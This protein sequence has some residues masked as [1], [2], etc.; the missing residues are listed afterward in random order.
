MGRKTDGRVD[1]GGPPVMVVS[2]R[3]RTVE[4]IYADFANRHSA[5]VRALT[6]DIDEVYSLCD[7]EKDSLCLH[8]QPNGLWEVVL[9]EE[10][11]PPEI[12]EP[13]QGINFYRDAMLQKEWISLLAMHSDS[14]LLAV[15]F[16]FGAELNAIERER[17]FNLINEL[18]TLF[19]SVNEEKSN[20][21]NGHSQ[22]KSRNRRKRPSERQ[23]RILP[24]PYNNS[25]REEQEEEED[26]TLCGRCG[27][28][29]GE[30]EFWIG[31]DVCERWFH[32]K[33]V[34]VTPAKAETIEKYMCPSCSSKR[35]RQ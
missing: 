18:P 5:L 9:P 32:G 11:V 8:A 1:F 4:E 7:P 3:P 17:L 31:C 30:D 33:C 12:P 29:G 26:E 27:Q 20:K 34:K 24:E 16:Y 22:N 13:L 15:A 2:S 14:W 23:E 19:E 6:Y 25:H 35:R 21:G 28:K 10:E